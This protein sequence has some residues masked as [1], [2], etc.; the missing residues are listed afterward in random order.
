[1]ARHTWMPYVAAVAGV[2]LLTKG[3]I[4]AA[5]GDESPDLATA[6]LYLG[7][8]A[9]GIAAAVGTGLRQPSPL[10]KVAVGTG[11]SLLLVAWMIGLGELVEP[12]ITLFTDVESRRQ[13]LP[14][15][16]AGLVVLGLAWRAR[17]NDL[18]AEEPVRAA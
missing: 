17:S 15:A 2:A 12:V 5:Q 9:L 11:L 18:A 10:R 1:M 13:E 6:V 16:F 7:G 3:L 14:I 8:I 4:A